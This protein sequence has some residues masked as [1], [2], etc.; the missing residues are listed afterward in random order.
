MKHNLSHTI[1]YRTWWR[2][3]N[4][5]TNPDD[6]NYS[7]YG[8]RG[9]NVADEWTQD[10]AAFIAHVG[11]RPSDQ[12]SLGRI[13]N[14]EGYVPGNV[15]WELPDQQARNRRPKSSSPGVAPYLNGYWRVSTPRHPQTKKFF[16][17]GR[18]FQSQ[19]EGSQAREEWLKANWPEY[20]D[21]HPLTAW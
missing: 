3:V 14:D 18:K 1:E 21:G 7:H 17:I 20:P 12:H 2:M 4:R 8:G 10:P 11:P 16:Y 9:I 5:C 13:K 6:V 19:E 15:R